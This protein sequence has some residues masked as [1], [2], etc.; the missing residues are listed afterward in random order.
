MI[1]RRKQYAVLKVNTKLTIEHTRDLRD[2][3]NVG[4]T[5]YPFLFTWSSINLTTVL[6]YDALI[7]SY[8]RSRRSVD[9]QGEKKPHFI[10]IAG[11]LD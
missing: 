4:F 7:A 8:V 2:S 3:I 11:R 6:F 9:E 10:D 5:E 1:F